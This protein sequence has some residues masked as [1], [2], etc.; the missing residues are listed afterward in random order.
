M[1]TKEKDASRED[2]TESQRASDAKQNLRGF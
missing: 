1:S 2:G